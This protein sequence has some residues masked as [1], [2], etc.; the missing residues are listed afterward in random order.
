VI[1]IPR[2]T[3][4]ALIIMAV[5]VSLEIFAGRLKPTLLVS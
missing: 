5:R 1:T 4:L 2:R 3:S